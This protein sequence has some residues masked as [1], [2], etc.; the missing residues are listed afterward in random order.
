MKLAPLAVITMMVSG[1]LYAQD[2]VQEGTIPYHI[3]TQA[4]QK[5]LHATAQKA[6]TNIR[7]MKIRLSEKAQKQLPKRV[8]MAKLKPLMAASAGLPKR[9][10][11]GMNK[12]PVLNQGAHGSQSVTPM[13]SGV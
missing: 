5:G 7:L 12:V 4:A 1:G 2:I 6:S 9:V 8:Q 13:A 11:L 3:K 10:Q